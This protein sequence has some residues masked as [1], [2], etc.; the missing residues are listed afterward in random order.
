MKTAIQRLPSVR[1]AQVMPIEDS[2]DTQSDTAHA[3]HDSGGSSRDGYE[4]DELADLPAEQVAQTL[5]SEVSSMSDVC[6]LQ[7]L[8]FQ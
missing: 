3:P 6:D 8:I 4:G 7:R 5:A 2:A 1:K